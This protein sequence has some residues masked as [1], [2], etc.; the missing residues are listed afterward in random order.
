MTLPTDELHT[1]TPTEAIPIVPA[2]VDGHAHGYDDDFLDDGFTAPLR[3]SRWTVALVAL[4]LV[5]IGFL[6]GVLVERTW[7]A[8]SAPQRTGPAATSTPRA[9]A[10]GPLGRL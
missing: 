2:E 4:L 6:A 5:A 9:G 10:A 8:S 3:R 7:G 1:E